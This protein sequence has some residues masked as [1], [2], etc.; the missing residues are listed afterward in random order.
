LKFYL[1]NYRLEWEIWC[2]SGTMQKGTVE[3]IDITAQISKIIQLDYGDFQ[4]KANKKY[5]LNLKIL[6][7]QSQSLIPAKHE[8]ATEQLA[9]PFNNRVKVLG[10]IKEKHADKL[11][12][13]A[14]ADKIQLKHPQLVATISKESGLLMSLKYEGRELLANPPIPNFWRAPI[15]NDFGWGMPEKTKIWQHAGKNRIVQSVNLISRL[16]TDITVS[17]FFDLPDIQA[18]F[19]LD[20]I[21]SIEGTLLINAHSIG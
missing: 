5:F 20:Y 21:L 11:D 7:K 14:T 17:T 3:K 2:S 6:T 1:D 9:F 13:K 19:K 16:P 15:D 18:Q 4:K 12:Y 10:I 8:V